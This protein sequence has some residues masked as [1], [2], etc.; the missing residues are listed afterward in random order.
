MNEFKMICSQK[1]SFQRDMKKEARVR[2]GL[3]PLGEGNPSRTW[4][5]SSRL[6][7][8]YMESM[9]HHLEDRSINMKYLNEPKGEKTMYE[10][11][12]TMEEPYDHSK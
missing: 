12:K 6:M 11:K 4:E 9:G 3:G 10:N 1:A 7:L 5:S 8:T 2:M